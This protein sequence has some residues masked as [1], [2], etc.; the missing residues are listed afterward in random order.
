MGLLRYATGRWQAILGQSHFQYWLQKYMWKYLDNATVTFPYPAWRNLVLVM[1]IRERTH[2]C[3]LTLVLL[4]KLS[5]HSHFWFS[6]NRITW[7][8]LLIQIHILNGKQCRSRSVGFFRSQL[9]WI[10]TVCKGRIYPGS[11]GQ[12]LNYGAFFRQKCIWN[13]HVLKNKMQVLGQIGL[14]KL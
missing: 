1:V 12:G 6:A 14:F 8:G 5:C 2:L 4:N 11:A 10:Y 7:S 3:S 13:W 9:I